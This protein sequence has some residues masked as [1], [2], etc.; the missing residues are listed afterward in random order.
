MMRRCPRTDTGC[1]D[2]RCVANNSCLIRDGL[3]PDP[4]LPAMAQVAQKLKKDIGVAVTDLIKEF[5]KETGLAPSNIRINLIDTR[6]VGG[7]GPDFMVASVDV[8]ITV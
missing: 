1:D 2:L 4:N 3:K 5:Q 7:R 8:E 6:S